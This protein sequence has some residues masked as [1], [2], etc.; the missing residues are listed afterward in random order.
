MKFVFV[1]GR[2]A[3]IVRYW[4]QRDKTVEGGARVELRRIEQVEGRSHRAGAA[5]F[6]VLPVSDGGLWRADLFMVLTE[7]GTSCFHYHPHVEHDDVGERFF[8]DELTG[9]PAKW[10]ETQLTDIAGT[11]ERCG[12]G[13]LVPSLDLEEH[14]RALPL[15]LAAVD[16]CLA[17]V[18][19]AM[20]AA[21]QT[22]V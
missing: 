10:I 12:A 9:D 14:R 4:E 1:N 19:A 17:R 6:T 16:A 3:I 5:G 18:P 2:V 7:P 8:E 15:I 13:N 21:R 20:V 11:L 22:R